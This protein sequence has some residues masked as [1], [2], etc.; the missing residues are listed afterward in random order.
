MLTVVAYHCFYGN[1]ND[2][3]RYA[4]TAFGTKKFDRFSDDDA[5][6]ALDYPDPPSVTVILPLFPKVDK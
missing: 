3:E 4:R 6:R 5:K 2:R 1:P